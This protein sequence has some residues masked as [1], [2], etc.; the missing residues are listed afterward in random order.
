[1]AATVPPEQA[2]STG[3]A[4]PPLEATDRARST[5][6]VDGEVTNCNLQFSKS[7]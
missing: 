5:V 3:G 7:F 1:M 2:P 4:G 6:L